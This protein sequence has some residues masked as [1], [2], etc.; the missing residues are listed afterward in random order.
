MPARCHALFWKLNAA[1]SHQDDGARAALV[2][3][4]LP[5]TSALFVTCKNERVCVRVLWSH[6]QSATECHFILEI[7]QVVWA[8]CKHMHACRRRFSYGHCSFFAHCNI[9]HNFN[10][11]TIAPFRCGKYTTPLIHSVN[12]SLIIYTFAIARFLTYELTGQVCVS[13]MF[14]VYPQFVCPCKLRVCVCVCVKAI[15]EGGLVVI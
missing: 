9:Q 11:I 5:T 3:R 4:C 12:R 15:G 13:A 10:C 2:S 14:F 1:P 6:R 7:I 8:E